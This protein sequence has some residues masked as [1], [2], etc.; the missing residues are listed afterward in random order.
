MVTAIS[1]MVT[2]I[3]RAGIVISQIVT[4]IFQMVTVIL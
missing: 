1:Q 4:V 3:L 2:T